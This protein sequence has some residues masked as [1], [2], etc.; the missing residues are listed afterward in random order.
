MPSAE[1]AEGPGSPPA[2][3]ALLRRRFALL[4]MLSGSVDDP[5]RTLAVG[6][7][8]SLVD[9]GLNGE[10]SPCLARHNVWPRL[11]RCCIAHSGERLEMGSR[12]FVG[13]PEGGG[14]GRRVHLVHSTDLGE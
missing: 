7:R 3:F 6:A 8:G 12:S 14:N 2:S 5:S 9:H 4:A 10:G 11:V 13:A 1:H